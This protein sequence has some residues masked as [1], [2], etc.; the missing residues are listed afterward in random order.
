M[1]GLGRESTALDVVRGVDLRGRLAVLTG[2]SSGIG[3]ETA[4]ALALTGADV[5]LA[6]RDVA[7]GEALA[8]EV[9]VGAT[10]DVRVRRLDL[11]DLG[12]VTAFADQVT[13]PVDLL[14]ANAG[15]SRTPD[16][17]LP[18]GL[19]VRF[20]TNH[21]GHFLL[22]LCL[23]DQLAERGARIVV[24][25]S[26]AHKNAPVRLDDLQWTAR[27]HN[28]LLAYAESKTANI[29]FAQEATRR[30]GPDGI[31]ANAVL[32]GSALTGLQRFHGDELKRRIGFLT[33]DGTPSPVLK[34]TA[35]A[36]A[37][38]LWAATAPELT[39]RGGLVLEDCAE[40]LPPDPAGSDTLRRSGFDPAVTDPDTAR[41]LW[42]HSLALLHALAG[43]AG[44]RDLEQSDPPTDAT[45]PPHS[46][47][48]M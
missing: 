33:A 39:G 48:S 12:S 40:A 31:F 24:V 2:A 17:H 22:A 26:G 38:T 32:P 37:T 45:L 9:R 36:A 35:Q 28:M 42:D 30:W 14:V 8:R 18:N 1:T 20:A 5:V 3:A 6:V 41:R 7:A 4:R 43:T 47:R 19:D 13:G 44:L 21:L 16:S 15:V 10:G 27:Q 46:H 29:L 25:S 34:T 11:R 23:R